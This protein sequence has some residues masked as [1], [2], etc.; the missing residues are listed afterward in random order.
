[1]DFLLNLKPKSYIYKNGKRRHYGLIAQDLLNT[2]RKLN[3]STNDF[4]GFVQDD[5]EQKMMAI[6]CTHLIQGIQELQVKLI[7]LERKLNY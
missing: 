2:L 5:T 1:M 3:I 4:S 7:D 6:R